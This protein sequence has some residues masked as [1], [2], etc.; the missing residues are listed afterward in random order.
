MLFC[1]Y[2]WHSNTSQK[3]FFNAFPSSKVNPEVRSW[4][5]TR[6]R[7]HGNVIYL[8]SHTH[9]QAGHTRQYTGRVL[10][11]AWRWQQRCGPYKLSSNLHISVFSEL[12]QWSR[13]FFPTLLGLYRAGYISSGRRNKFYTVWKCK[14]VKNGVRHSFRLKDS[15]KP[16]VSAQAALLPSLYV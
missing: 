2:Y 12:S 14:G 9:S 10:L 8:S 3:L 4:N 15:L 11:S 1:N 6:D 13:L 16:M 7:V 5:R